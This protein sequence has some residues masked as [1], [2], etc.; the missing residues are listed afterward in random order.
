MVGIQWPFFYPIVSSFSY[1]FNST[2]FAF[3]IDECLICRCVV[4][5]G[6]LLTRCLVDVIY[7]SIGYIV[8][9]INTNVKNNK[10]IRVK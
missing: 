2:T 3:C 4:L 1:L 6:N 9:V 5:M 10:N 8:F 7:T